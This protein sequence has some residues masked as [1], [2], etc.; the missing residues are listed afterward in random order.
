MAGS[1]L[2]DWNI[3]PDPETLDYHLKQWSEPYRS[4]VHF[5]DFLEDRLEI[6]DAV[7]DAGCGGGAPTW[8]LANRFLNCAFT[9]ID[10]SK[11]LIAHA[12]R[13][14]NLDFEVD[15]LT[16]LRVRFG[17][18][19]V[20]LMQTLH[21]FPSPQI[22]IHQIA[23]RIR[24][25]WIAFSTLIYEGNINCKIIVSEPDR[26]RE[27]YYNVYGLPGISAVLGSEGYG[28]VRYKPFKI[29]VDLP[30]PN[31]PDIMKTYTLATESSKIQ[32]SG[33]LVLPWGFC[34]FE[35]RHDLSH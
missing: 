22:P 20:V 21:C 23:T 33:P 14:R 2:N 17:I 8:Y 13:A 31:N 16:S 4:T 12:R 5:A 35:R 3:N 26:P 1:C 18:D 19:G 9:G 32:C 28:I 34:L 30:R 10:E 15:D 6:A 24:P 11:E 27:S 29:D 7:I 25:Q